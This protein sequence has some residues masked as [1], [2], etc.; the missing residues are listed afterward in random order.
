MDCIH[1]FQLNKEELPV[2]LIHLAEA[3]SITI[4]VIELRVHV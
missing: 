1:D 4:H 3:A 2:M